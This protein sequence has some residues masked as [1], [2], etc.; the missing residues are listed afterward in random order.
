MSRLRATL[1]TN[2]PQ[3]EAVLLFSTLNLLACAMRDNAPVWLYFVAGGFWP[4]VAL[5]Y[6]LIDPLPVERR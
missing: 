2:E 3:V 5:I 6:N 1:R 4:T